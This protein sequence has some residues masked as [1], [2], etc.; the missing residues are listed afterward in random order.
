MQFTMQAMVNI[1]VSMKL[2]P[3]KGMTLPFISYGGS[4]MLSTAIC[5]GLILAFTKRKYHENVDYG[6]LKLI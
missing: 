2:L 6:N 4:S 5:F 1:G 3:T